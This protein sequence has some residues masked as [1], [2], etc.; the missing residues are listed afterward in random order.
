MAPRGA[1]LLLLLLLLGALRAHGAAPPPGRGERAGPRWLWA[2]A[3]EEEEEDGDE[4][5][6]LSRRKR[7]AGGWP[8]DAAD[9]TAGYPSPAAGKSNSSEPAWLL[10]SLAPGTDGSLQHTFAA[11]TTTDP[12]DETDTADP[13]LLPSSAAP[14]TNSS[15]LQ[16]F[17]APTTTDLPDETDPPDPDLL[18]NS[19]ALGTNAS[20]PRAFAVPT[21]MD[22]PDET[23]LPDPDLLPSSAA[24]GTNASFP[25]AFAVPTTTDPPDETDPPDPDLLPSSAVPSTP[26]HRSAMPGNGT[27]HPPAAAVSSSLGS[28]TASAG[29]ALSG[30]GQR[31][32]SSP[33]PGSAGTGAAGK[34]GAPA[35]PMQPGQQDTAPAGETPGEGATAVLMGK[36]LLAIFLLALVAATFIVCTAVLGSLLWRRRRAGSRRLSRTE[37]VCISS[38]LPDGEPAANGARPGPAKRLKVLPETG[39]E[40]EGDDLTLSSFLPDHS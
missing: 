27:E 4:L 17:T 9:T 15:L 10:S 36:C 39:S 12:L 18:P 19:T 30:G 29:T 5:P 11:L 24:P 40:A 3:P 16:A 28:P 23:D 8:S 26:V 33:A 6:P 31:E 1:V 32:R 25:H 14:G 38:L 35:V 7:D 22:P 20:L 13:D 2:T 34:P 21:T 37:M